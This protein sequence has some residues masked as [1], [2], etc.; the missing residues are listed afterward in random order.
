MSSPVTYATHFAPLVD[1]LQELERNG[2]YSVTGSLDTPMPALEVT[3]MGPVS[4]PVPTDQARRLITV[5]GERAPYGKGEQTLVDESVRKVW[6]VSPAAITLGGRG[7][8]AGFPGLLTRVATGLGLDPTQVEAEFYKLLIYDEGAFF[9][10][11]RDSEKAGGMFGT[12]VVSLPSSHTGGQLHIRHAGRETVFDL[13]CSDPGEIRFAAFYADCEH[14]VLPVTSGHRVC[15][16]YNLVQ[17]T[18]RAS[19]P[20]PD[21]RPA[22]RAAA[23]VL[24]PWVDRSFPSLDAPF[25]DAECDNENDTEANPSPDKLV[26]LLDHHY[27]QASLSF[28]GLKG[29]DA[30]V[31]RVLAAAARLSDCAAHLGI[32]H[33]EESGWAEYHGDYS[34][35]R[36]RWRRDYDDEK[37]E[38]EEDGDDSEYE[39]G[40]VLDGWEYIDQW[41]NDADQPVAYGQIPLGDQE[42]LPPGALDDTPADETHFSEATGNSGASFERTYLRAAIILWPESRFDAICASAGIDAA[43]ARLAQY[44]CSDASSR[45]RAKKLARIIHANWPPSHY[46][47]LAARVSGFLAALQS[48]DDAALWSEIAAPLLEENHHIDHNPA[49]A[50]ALAHFGPTVLTPA[51][52]R[53]FAQHAAARPAAFVDLWQ[54]LATAAPATGALLS[55]W[56]DSLLTAFN[57]ARSYTATPKAASNYDQGNSDNMPA[58]PPDAT[59]PATA[60]APAFLTG[61]LAQITHRLGPARATDAARVLAGNPRAFDARSFLVPILAAATTP[62]TAAPP[63]ALLDLIAQAAAGQLLQRSEHRPA[64]P[65]DWAQPVNFRGNT[66]EEHALLAFARDPEAQVLRIRANTG[67]R[68]PKRGLRPSPCCFPASRRP[69]AKRPSRVAFQFFDQRSQAFPEAFGFGGA[70]RPQQWEPAGSRRLLDAIHQFQ[71]RVLVTLRV[72]HEEK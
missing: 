3:G 66:P 68:F 36:G 57:T 72:R 59:A 5:A 2:E 48:L 52:D 58:S 37:G 46:L 30:A 65:T 39:V 34:Y 4:F 69:S 33:I 24:R 8:L 15:L 9:R 13:A 19:L 27:T 50:R 18:G 23:D 31:A 21:E 60:E 38:E 17:R 1:A 6:Q 25:D 42:V 41:R 29:R 44:D 49:L 55:T 51:I 56:L 11:H 20:V 14:E 22:A 70:P 35:G 53:L 54:H 45:E 7:W 12:L 63:A 62:T 32:V 16:I 71:N 64:K 10:A 28:A 47:W 26:Y 61:F 43:L 67:I 40:E